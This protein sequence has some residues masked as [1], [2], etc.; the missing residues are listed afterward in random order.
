MSFDTDLFI[1]TIEQKR[2]IWNT[3]CTEYRN[4]D[5]KLK[6]WEDIGGAMNLNFKDFTG[7]Q[8]DDYS[9]YNMC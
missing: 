5:I 7:K 8:K 4:R 2:S 1:I 6:D 3:S 9:E